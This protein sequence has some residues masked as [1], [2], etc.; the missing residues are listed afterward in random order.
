RRHLSIAALLRV[1]TLVVCVNKMDRVDFDAARFQ[2][3]AEE[4]SQIVREVSE[5]EY[6]L[7]PEL[8][9]IPTSA[10][11]GDNV[12]TA[13]SR[14]PFYEGPPL[15]TALEGAR[16]SL[17]D[18]AG[19]AR[20]PV[21]WVL[22]PQH[23]DFE[24]YRGYAARIARG[25]IA[26]GD[27]V[28]SVRSGQEARVTELTGAGAERATRH[29]GE[30]VVLQLSAPIDVSRGDV[31]VNAAEPPPLVS[32]GATATLL[33]LTETPLVESAPLLVKHGTRTQR[34]RVRLRPE[35]FFVRAELEFDEPLVFDRFDDDRTFGSFVAIDPQS[36]STVAA[37]L[38]RGAS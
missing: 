19:P 11:H 3:L 32:R 31:L 18:E 13:S 35:G 12:V 36:G 27:R 28:R 15:L 2:E 7:A 10:L 14:M 23:D 29:A 9:A 5:R 6:G 25:R 21:Q 37:G 34:A 26:R 22:R 1:G 24:D 16:G 8:L 4:A 17:R 38:L 33:C 20:I 30:S